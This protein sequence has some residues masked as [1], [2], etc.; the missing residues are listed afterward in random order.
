MLEVEKYYRILELEP[1]ASQEEIH[2]G[3]LDLTWVWHPDRF[4]GNPRL[5][6]KAH[7]KLQQINEAHAQL[8]SLQRTLG[9]KN[10]HPKPKPQKQSPLKNQYRQSGLYK[11][12]VNPVTTEAS[13][14]KTGSQNQ[15]SPKSRRVYTSQK[16]DD[17]LD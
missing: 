10:R 3:Y 13:E 9:W 4:S 14:S 2:Q 15:G 6:Q 16:I 17:W 7:C 1:G 5:Q 12:E 8:R 11:R